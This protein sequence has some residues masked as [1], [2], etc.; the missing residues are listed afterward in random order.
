MYF[1]WCFCSEL[2]IWS[3]FSRYIYIHKNSH[4]RFNRYV[5]LN[6]CKNIWPCTNR[7][8]RWK[9]LRRHI[10]SNTHTNTLR[11][12][13]PL[14]TIASYCTW[15]L[16]MVAC[17]TPVC[18]FISTEVNLGVCLCSAIFNGGWL[19]TGYLLFLFC[20]GTMKGRDHWAT[21]AF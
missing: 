1:K 12:Q 7:L 20:G 3:K 8:N 2:L 15:S 4:S 13:H 16:E 14:A 6:I 11:W 10:R 21:Q 9:E 5:S 19:L 18:H 17:F